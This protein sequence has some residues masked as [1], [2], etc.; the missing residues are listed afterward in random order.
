MKV[1]LFVISLLFSLQINVYTTYEILNCRS[2]NS[3]KFQNILLQVMS[4]C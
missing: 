4:T 1:I 2:H 3:I